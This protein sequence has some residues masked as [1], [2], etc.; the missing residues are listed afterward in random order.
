MRLHLTQASRT[1]AWLHQFELDRALA[2]GADPSAS[3]A[4]STRAHQ[5]QSPHVRRELLAQ[6]DSALARAE[7]PPHW[8]TPS[9]P[10][11]AAE[12]RA[13][14]ADLEAL[15]AL[16]DGPAACAVR[17]IALAS[18]LINDPTGPLYHPG[19]TTIAE[20][21]QAACASIEPV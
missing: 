1:W 11:L 9:L 13:A 10:V 18:C 6:L 16:L 14:K 21:A 12:I 15:R 2:A 3:P 4:L 8:H 19:E 5:L 20:L 17:G 7:H